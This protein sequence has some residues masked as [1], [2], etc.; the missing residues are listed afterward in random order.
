[1]ERKGGRLGLVFHC[2]G[3]AKSVSNRNMNKVAQRRITSV[4][5]GSKPSGTQVNCNHGGKGAGGEWMRIHPGR[6]QRA[7]PYAESHTS[8]EGGNSFFSPQRT[9]NGKIRLLHVLYSLS[10]YVVEREHIHVEYYMYMYS[11]S[12]SKA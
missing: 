11:S 4:T 9:M 10:S 12:T 8:V 6:Q 3:C 7:R 5:E 2:S 1:M